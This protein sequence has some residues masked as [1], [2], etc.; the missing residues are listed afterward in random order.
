MVICLVTEK[1]GTPVFGDK[2][3]IETCARF[4]SVIIEQ[5]FDL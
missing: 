3:L 4:S 5:K 2:V 1:I